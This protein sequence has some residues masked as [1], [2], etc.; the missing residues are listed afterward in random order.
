MKRQINEIIL[1]PQA[2]RHM[3]ELGEDTGLSELQEY[4]DNTFGADGW[5]YVSGRV[6]PKSTRRWWQVGPLAPTRISSVVIREVS[7]EMCIER[8]RGYD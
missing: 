5:E 2:V 1:E 6:T 4:L 7:P 3:Y 8:W